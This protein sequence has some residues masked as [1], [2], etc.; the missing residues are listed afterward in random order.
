M[1]DTPPRSDVLHDWEMVSYQPETLEESEDWEFLPSLEVPR[2]IKNHDTLPFDTPACTLS[3]SSSSAAS[4]VDRDLSATPELVT[5]TCECMN[6]YDYC[7]ERCGDF[8]PSWMTGDA[9]FNALPENTDT[10]LAG[11]GQSGMGFLGLHR[12]SPF[13]AQI[14]LLAMESPET[15]E[16]ALAL[17]V[18]SLYNHPRSTQPEPQSQQDLLNTLTQGYVAPYRWKFSFYSRIFKADYSLQY[19]TSLTY[20]TKFTTSEAVFFWRHHFWGRGLGVGK[21][22]EECGIG[23]ASHRRGNGSSLLIF[24]RV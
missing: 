10:A 8:Y 9:A 3:A 14:M 4:S 16:I 11:N 23:K 2:R 18:L 6:P 20:S 24:C 1:S 5:S 21:G 19:G 12:L 7:L 22:K 17:L 13:W 15:P